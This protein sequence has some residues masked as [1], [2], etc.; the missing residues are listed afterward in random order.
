LRRERC[1]VVEAYRST[2]AQA[3]KRFGGRH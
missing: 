3:F 2:V 1:A